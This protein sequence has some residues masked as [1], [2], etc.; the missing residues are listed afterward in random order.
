MNAEF[1]AFA[2]YCIELRKV[3]PS[4]LPSLRRWRNSPKIR[5]QM[6]DTSHISPQQQRR[7]FESISKRVDQ[8]HWV[9][10][11]DG[12]RTGYVNVKAGGQLVSGGYYIADTPVRHPLLGYA[13]VLMYHDIIFDHFRAQGIKDTVLKTNA[14]ARKMNEQ[15]GY[16]EGPEEGGIIAIT[17]DPAD[18]RG[19]R[20]KFLR[21]FKDTQCRPTS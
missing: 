7:W 17:L 5:E 9:V 20:K 14:V 18:Y 10:W 2:G 11:N 19:A 3:T 1:G 16:R 8:A 6:L 12:V 15:M 13:T 4:D 21:F